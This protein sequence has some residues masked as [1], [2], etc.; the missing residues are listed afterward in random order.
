[1]RLI[2]ADKLEEMIFSNRYYTSTLTV[3]GFKAL[4]DDCPTIEIEPEQGRW[5]F[6]AEWKYKH[7]NGRGVEHKEI[8]GTTKRTFNRLKC[9]ECKKVVV[10]DDT[11][12]YAYCPHCGARME[13][14]E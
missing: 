3:R 12:H 14:E 11:I 4:M 8:F 9:S 2:D 7:C 6:E 10:V 5:I 1:M 13:K